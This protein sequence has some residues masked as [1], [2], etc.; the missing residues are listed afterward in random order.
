MIGISSFRRENK[1]HLLNET[2]DALAQTVSNIA[3][4][5]HKIDLQFDFHYPDV[6][7]SDYNTK[8]LS[9]YWLHQNIFI[10]HIVIG[11]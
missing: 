10:R 2:L 4:S 6:S 11:S 1:L 9:L 3:L 7:K 5:V 8:V